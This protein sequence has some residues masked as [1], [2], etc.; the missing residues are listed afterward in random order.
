ME[1]LQL[2][3]YLVLNVKKNYHFHA[4]NFVLMKLLTYSATFCP[5]F[6]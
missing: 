1:T 5:I 6:H 3:K 2:D 4:L